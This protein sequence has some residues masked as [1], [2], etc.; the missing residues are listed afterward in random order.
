MNTSWEALSDL[1]QAVEAWSHGEMVNVYATDADGTF[2]DEFNTNA[3]DVAKWRVNKKILR[4][5]PEA[6][7]RLTPEAER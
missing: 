5:H 6:S 3:E 1:P 4:F 7:I 2:L